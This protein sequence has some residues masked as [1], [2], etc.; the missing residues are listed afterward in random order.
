[1]A[2]E[3]LA[4]LLAPINGLLAT[5]YL[6]AVGLVCALYDHILT[7]HEEWQYMWLRDRWDST[8][9]IFF[10]IRYCNEGGLLCV[11]YIFSGMR[12]DLTD[13]NCKGFFLSLGLLGIVAIGCANGF[14]TLR[15]YALWDRRR[16]AKIALFSI[17]GI[18]YGAIA[19]LAVFTLVELCQTTYYDT[20]YRVCLVHKKPW[21]II[22]V[23]AAM[24]IFDVV[25]LLLAVSN[26]LDQPY[27]ET[28]E[29]LERF[30]RD[31]AI[32]FVT[33]LVLRLT[34]FICALVL[35][36]YDLVI[37]LYFVWAMVTVITCRLMLRV[38][39]IRVEAGKLPAYSP[40]AGNSSQ[41]EYL[42]MN[43][44]NRTGTR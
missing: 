26:A 44:F 15:H 31:G 7:F 22:G 34:N 14:M 12:G 18:T 43:C 30:R 6:A 4:Q 32:F 8:R 42:E 16:W 36:H 10:M 21:M 20:T 2:S 13:A 41:D 27:R 3:T 25:T 37:T 28:V 11:A 39:E 5:R 17:F 33:L 9:V 29:V 38:A 1:M 40:Q 19:V 23:W 24:S 35:P